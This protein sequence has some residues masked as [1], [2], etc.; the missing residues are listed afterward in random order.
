VAVYQKNDKHLVQ[1]IG[2]LLET[3]LDQ[4]ISLENLDEDSFKRHP[5]PC[6]TSY[7]DAL[8][9][10]TDISSAPKPHVL[11]E[12]SEYTD[13]EEHKKFLKCISS[14]TEEGKQVY[15][16]W[17]VEKLRNI[18][19]VLEDMPSVKPRLDHLLEIL[20]RLLPRFYTICSSSKVYPN[21]V[22]LTA[23]VVKKS[24]GRV[25]KGVATNLLASKQC[26]QSGDK[27]S[28]PIF[29]RRSQF[30]LPVNPET[31]VIMIGPGTGLAP[32]RGF[33]QE[34]WYHKQNQ[35]PI[36]PTVLYFGCRNQSDDYLY[37]EEL[38]GYVMDNT[39]T[40]LYTAFSRDGSDKVYVTHLLR[41][42]MPEIWR[43][44]GPL[45]GHVYV[46]GYA[47]TMAREVKDILVD[48]FVAEGN[49]SPEE[50]HNYLKTME[51][52]RRYLSDVWS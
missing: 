9:F 2:Q 21:S 23:V 52:Q 41:Q 26:E 6:P 14:S 38:R 15:N 36:G 31:P 42:H 51:S 49:Q 5:F 12:L 33:L 46:S 34:R 48:T 40:K 28:V 47:S 4:V 32:F 22:H 25:N 27:V 30:R 13:N 11:R 16:E 35:T 24:T 29:I 37:E 39:L 18:V 19:D 43:L 8:L 44:I 20:P 7:R 1:R 50:A 10:Y 45:N 17:I 3:D